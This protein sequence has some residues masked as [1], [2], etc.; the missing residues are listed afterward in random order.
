MH[1]EVLLHGLEGCDRPTELAPLAG[2]GDRQPGHRGER[3]GD[4]R[5]ARQRAALEQIACRRPRVLD[6]SARSKKQRVARLAG[7]VRVPLD[8]R[9]RCD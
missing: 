2:V 1:D 6:G 5:G 8:A 3:A 4:Q 7:E 9:G